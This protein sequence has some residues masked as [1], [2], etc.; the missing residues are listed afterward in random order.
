[1]RPSWG[2]RRLPNIMAAW[3]HRDVRQLAWIVFR[4]IVAPVAVILL[5][6]VTWDF[7]ETSRLDKEM[8]RIRATGAPV[9]PEECI[10]EPVP[11]EDNGA[12]LI[13][14]AGRLMKS[15]NL[16]SKK[17]Q[18]VEMKQ[19]RNEAWTDDDVAVLQEI[20]EREDVASGLRKFEEACQRAHCVFPYDYHRGGSTAA[21]LKSNEQNMLFLELNRLE[22]MRMDVALALSNYDTAF[23]SLERQLYLARALDGSNITTTALTGDAMISMVLT[24]TGTMVGEHDLSVSDL[25]R[26]RDLIERTVGGTSLADLWRVERAVTFDWWVSPQG[27]AIHRNWPLRILYRAGSPALKRSLRHYLVVTERAIT[28][29]TLPGLQR[30]DALEKLDAEVESNVGF[31][32]KQTWYQY[33][34]KFAIFSVSPLIEDALRSSLQVTI[35][36]RL[37]E[38][39][40]DMLPARLQDLVPGYLPELPKDPFTGKE[41]LLKV[42]GESVTVYSVGANGVDDGGTLGGNEDVGV[43]LL[44][45]EAEAS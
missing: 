44:K 43:R 27:L 13:L 12:Q 11:E 8:K 28:Y 1:M 41:L 23:Q 38:E 45:L 42:G 4:F 5:G 22:Q 25:K 35:A 14:E 26:A 2:E 9:S 32:D 31:V 18:D 20:L 3:R 34:V 40:T 39:E 37:H 17:L 33:P 19:A 36:M 21:F 16:R 15:L 29:A 7:V 24:G 30:R 10:P 6:Y